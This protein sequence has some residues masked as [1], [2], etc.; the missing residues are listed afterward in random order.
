MVAGSSP[1][2]RATFR[3]SDRGSGQRI[4]QQ[5]GTVKARPSHWGGGPPSSSTRARVTLH[6]LHHASMSSASA[7]GSVT[8]AGAVV[9]LFPFQRRRAQPLES[10]WRSSGRARWSRHSR[11]A[12]RSSILAGCERLAFFR[13][14]RVRAPRPAGL[15]RSGPGW[16][17]RTAGSNRLPSGEVDPDRTLRFGFDDGP[18][19]T[20][21]DGYVRSLRL[22]SF[23]RRRFRVPW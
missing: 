4:G 10:E 8:W 2:G 11:P 16:I 15:I 6:G 12:S 14:R 13:R 5:D 17:L 22:S 1:A 7:V 19:A 21:L 20:G 3:E 23:C 18:S 9:V